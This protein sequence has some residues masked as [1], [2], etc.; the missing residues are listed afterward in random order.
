MEFFPCLWS[1]QL[2]H[3]RRR[4]RWSAQPH[5][6]TLSDESVL[7]QPLSFR[8]AA[9][10]HT[11]APYRESTSTADS[12]FGTPKDHRKVAQK[13]AIDSAFGGLHEVIFDLLENSFFGG[14]VVCRQRF[15][16]LLE[17]LLLIARELG[18]GFHFEMDHD[19]TTSVAVHMRHALMAYAQLR[20]RLRAFRNFEVLRLLQ[21][22]DF[23]LGTQRGLRDIHRNRAMQVVLVA[24]EERVFLDLE[25]D[26]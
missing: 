8:R 25:H 21:R 4:R 23:D 17:Q 19:V 18:G 26:V 16:K 13:A 1:F 11:S 12:T 7:V 22:G 14:L 5:K 9:P 10:R 15:P 3:D 6:A 24:L 2:G 20:A